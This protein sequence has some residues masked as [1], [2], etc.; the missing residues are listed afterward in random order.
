MPGLEDVLKQIIPQ[1]RESDLLFRGES[2]WYAS[3]HSSSYRLTALE[4][5]FAENAPLNPGEMVLLKIFFEDVWEEVILAYFEFMNHEQEVPGTYQVGEAV[6]G[7][8]QHYHIPTNFIDLTSDLFVATTFAVEGYEYLQPGE[9]KNGQLF[10]IDRVEFMKAGGE[11]FE[12]AHEIACRPRVQ[13][14]VPFYLPNG[15]DF[16]HLPE[17]IVRRYQFSATRAECEKFSRGGIYDASNDPIANLMATVIKKRI[18]RPLPDPV[19]GVAAM[20]RLRAIL[21]R[22]ES[23]GAKVNSA[24]E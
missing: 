20:D 10:T 5:L 18:E 6:Y 17:H 21:V 24:L 22:L 9:L 16:Q 12:S 2:A 11:F 19:M 4:Y 3:T 13:K 1:M 14:A 8:L 23:Y 15:I 7:V